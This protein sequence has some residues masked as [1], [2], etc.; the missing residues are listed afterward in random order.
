MVTDITTVVKKSYCVL[1]KSHLASV[2]LHTAFTS[3][4]KC[5]FLFHFLFCFVLFCFTQPWKG[6]SLMKSDFSSVWLVITQAAVKTQAYKLGYKLVIDSTK[7]DTNDI[8]KIIRYQFTIAT[9]AQ[10]LSQHGTAHLSL[11]FAVTVCIFYLCFLEKWEQ[12]GTEI[13]MT[14]SA[15]PND[16]DQY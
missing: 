15:P 8:N 2:I 16:T 4:N 5:Y 11:Q 10:R 3:S 13:N 1:Q 9:L 6:T 12:E 14:S 7:R